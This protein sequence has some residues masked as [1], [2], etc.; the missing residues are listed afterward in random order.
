MTA[1][2]IE[3]G[4]NYGSVRFGNVLGSSGSLI[5]LLQQQIREGGPVT[6]THKDMT[7]YFMLI[8]EAV[9]LVLK[10]STISRPGDINVLKMGE[11][12]KIVDIARSLM[13]LM[14]TSEEKIPIIYTGLRPGEKIFEE[15]YIRGDELK[16]E[17]P[18][19]LTLPNGDSSL[20]LASQFIKTLYQNLDQ[21]LDHAQEGRREEALRLLAILALNSI[22]T[23]KEP[24]RILSISQ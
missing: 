23:D 14:G 7:R 22:P 15:L 8:P 1:H 13:A 4:R 11:P 24:A 12:V 20:L 16:T 10:A 5:P 21:L 9:S 3:L 19:I 18:D 17:H 2:A 6:I